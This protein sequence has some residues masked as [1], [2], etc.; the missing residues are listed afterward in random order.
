MPVV[1]LDIGVDQGD[2]VVAPGSSNVGVGVLTEALISG[3]LIGD[4]GCKN[5]RCRENCLDRS[6]R[7]WLPVIR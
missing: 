1:R 5:E 6:A 7:G 4:E 3:I 2:R